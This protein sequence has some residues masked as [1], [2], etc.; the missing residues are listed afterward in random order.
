[1]AA[2][3]QQ[4]HTILSFLTTHVTHALTLLAID[5]HSAA[6][7]TSLARALVHVLPHVSVVHM[8]DFYRSMPEEER[9]SLD[10]TGGYQ[11]YYDWQRLEAQVLIP[12]KTGQISHYQKYNWATNRLDAWAI[13]PPDG[14]VVVE[15]CYAARPELRHYY[16]IIILVE[17][18]AQQ[19][20]CRQQARADASS[21]WLAR[22]DAAERYYMDRYR[23]HDYADLIVAGE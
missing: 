20:E 9:A 10:A 4:L 15:G 5:G 11:H 23:P 19:R 16:D 21:E 13:V 6:G 8:D 18:S 3:N 22:W 14:V 12:L 2:M 7:K 17:T 1:M